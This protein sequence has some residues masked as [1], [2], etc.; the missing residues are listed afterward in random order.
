MRDFSE[1]EGEFY[2]ASAHPRGRYR[3][4]LRPHFVFLFCV[5][6]A[7]RGCAVRND[8]LG[9]WVGCESLGGAF[10]VDLAG[11]FRDVRSCPSRVG[12]RG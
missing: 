10:P 5:G 2:E 4:S 1:G 11:V 3:V 7:E 6:K 12:C 9:A 8:G